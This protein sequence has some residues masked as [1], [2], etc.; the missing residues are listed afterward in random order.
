M[1][2]VHLWLGVGLG[3]FVAVVCVSGGIVAFRV[4]MNRLTTPGTAYVRPL[5]RRLPLDAM[6]AAVLKNR[7]GDTLH[8]VSMEAGPDVAWNVRTKSPE[9]HRIHT[10]VDQYRGVVT[11]C[12]DYS[13]K[14]LQWMWDLHA[15][16]LGGTTGR[17]VNGW[18]AITTLVVSIS[19]L[20][21]WWPGRRQL[22][23]GFTYALSAGWKRQNYDLHKVVGFW[24]F[25]LLA[26][27]SF[28]GAYFCFPD[29]YEAALA[30]LSHV[31]HVKA[32]DLCGEDGPPAKTLMRNRSI[33][34]EEYLRLAE[35]Q[36]PGSKAVFMSFPFYDGMS[37]GVKLKE[38]DD[39]HRVG[40]SN[41][42]LEPADGKIIYV[43]RYSENG[44]ATK[45][46]K[47][48]LPFHFGRFGEKLGM[49]SFGLYAVL[50]LY[51]LVGLGVGLLTVSGFLM[52]WNRYLGKKAKKW[53][54]RE[55]AA[56]SVENPAVS[57]QVSLRR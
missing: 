20:V 29:A 41:V 49:G 15:N 40:L 57:S 33:P 10:F 46:L 56:L 26:I 3:I 24:S 54:L 27:V 34:Y 9:G 8:N 45:F 35:R 55:P 28:T 31:A 6:L 12:D 17:L 11:G 19:G 43:D 2:Q 1:F 32:P 4:E 13:S 38:P 18:L 5:G 39:W 50:V 30:K 7:P 47:L 52:Y 53:R 48:M 51:T 37:V 25:G 44:A 21:I 22:K 16:L 14:F 23:S 36:I 42:Y